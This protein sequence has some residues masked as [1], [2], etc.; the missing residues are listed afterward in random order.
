MGILKYIQRLQHMD[1]LIRR[2]AT[3]E[4]EVFARKIGL[5]RSTL[6]DYL[7]ELREMGAPIGYC[8]NRGSYFY[9]EEKQLFIGYTDYQLPKQI[10]QKVIG[11]MGAL[12]PAPRHHYWPLLARLGAAA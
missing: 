10:E 1:S 5:C 9:K 2:S 7:R 4:P 6:M 8:K 3:G 12:S 11:G